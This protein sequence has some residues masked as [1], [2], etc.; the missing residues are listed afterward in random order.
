M[1]T[2][3]EV[4]TEKYKGCLI[5]I[6]QDTDYDQSPD[7]W[8]DDNLFLVAYHPDFTIKRDEII[9]KDE[10]RA[11]ITGEIDDTTGYYT[12]NIKE[13][14]RKYHFFGLEAYIHSGVNLSLSYEGNYPDR[15]WDVSQLGLVLVSKSKAKSREKARKLARELLEV[16]NDCL[17][18]NVY[19]FITTDEEA[20][21]DI[22]SCWGFIG[23]YDKTDILNEARG[24]IDNYIK[25]ERK[26]S[27]QKKID[28]SRL[29]LGEL[30]SSNDETIRRNAISI[31]KTLQRNA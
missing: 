8:E 9:T 21:K 2:F 12:H 18:G 1:E 15:R 13:L 31:L 3:N 26:E 29:S 19:G 4:Y 30:L 25:N 20:G 22:D 10:A 14:K 27:R 28:F 16:W 5:T 11:I 7:A 24:S 23:D 17:S 6:Y